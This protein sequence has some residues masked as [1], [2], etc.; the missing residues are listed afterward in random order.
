MF[1]ESSFFCFTGIY[2][3]NDDYD[4]HNNDYYENNCYNNKENDA[5]GGPGQQE[6]ALQDDIWRPKSAILRTADCRRVPGCQSAE[7]DVL[8]KK[9]KS[10]IVQ[11]NPEWATGY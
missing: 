9:T 6:P 5:Q 3:D 7:Q 11:G 8:L 2:D 10:L 4:N 1:S